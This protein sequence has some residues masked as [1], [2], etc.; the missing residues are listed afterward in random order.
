MSGPSAVAIGGDVAPTGAFVKLRD[1]GDQVTTG[2]RGGPAFFFHLS[3]PL[4]RNR[5]VAGELPFIMSEEDIAATIDE[6]R[7]RR[8]ELTHDYKR[9][10]KDAR[11]KVAK[12][13]HGSA[14]PVRRA[15]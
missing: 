12:R 9:K 14:P 13:K 15:R 4:L 3:K 6:W 7:G 1:A 5:L 11:R 10:M 8:S 2:L